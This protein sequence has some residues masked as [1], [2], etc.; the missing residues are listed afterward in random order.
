MPA[1]A[2]TGNGIVFAKEGAQVV[3]S[4]IDYAAAQT[5]TQKIKDMGS[6]AIAV[7]LT[8][9]IWRTFNHSLIKLSAISGNW[10]YW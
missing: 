10:I 2:L 5:T 3:V 1:T 7:K 8:Y 4:D 6:E 9:R